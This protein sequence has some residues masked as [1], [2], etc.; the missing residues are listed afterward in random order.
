MNY[1]KMNT[2]DFQKKVKEG[3]KIHNYKECFFTPSTP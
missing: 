3:A 1:A 2:I